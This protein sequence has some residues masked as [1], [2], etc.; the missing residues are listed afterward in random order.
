MSSRNIYLNPQ[1]R[2]EARI[3]A[4][5]LQEAKQ[6]IQKNKNNLKNIGQ[7]IKN[8]IKT[9]SS[10]RIDYVECVD[11]E[12]LLPIKQS[13]RNILIALAVWFGK[14]RL[15]DNISLSIR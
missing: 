15:I 11:A 9:H 12:N 2:H 5:S 6:K 7:E 13:S 1:E 8:K 4:Q 10:G 14:T 3:L